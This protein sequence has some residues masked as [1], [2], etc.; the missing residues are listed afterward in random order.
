MWWIIGILVYL[1]IAGFTYKQFVSK[2]NHPQWEKIWISLSWIC[3]IPLY[4]IRKIQEWVT[5]MNKD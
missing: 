3:I 5:G 2:W 1:V 4:G